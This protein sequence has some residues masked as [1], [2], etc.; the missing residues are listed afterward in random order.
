[1]IGNPFGPVINTGI[2]KQPVTSAFLHKTGFENDDVADHENH[3]GFDRAVCFYPFEHYAGWNKLSGTE[4][5]LPA[6]GENI[7]IAGYSEDDIC[8]GD[9]YKIGAA[10][11]QITQ[12]RIPCAKVDISNRVRG[13]FEQF[14]HTGK[15][16]YFAKVLE[17]GMV[18]RTSDIILIN[19]TENTVSVRGLHHLFFRDRKNL[20]EIERVLSIEGLA[21]DM[22]GRLIKIL[23]RQS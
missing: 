11:V 15:T 19:R 4:L 13:L 21:E 22:K 5:R 7:T 20:K 3:G 9:I 17:E 12:S 2:K 10:T 23:N 16:G 18:E 8:I 1:M 14:I 6:F